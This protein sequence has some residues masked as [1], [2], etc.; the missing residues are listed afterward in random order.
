MAEAETAVIESFGGR[1]G[2]A[3]YTVL[4]EEALVGPECSLLVFTDGKSVL[5]MAPAQDH[6][7]IGEGDT[8]PNTGGMGVYSPVPFVTATEHDQMVKILERTI[9]GL[10]SQ[11]IDY[12]GVLYGGFMLTN[13]GP[14]LLEFNA[15]FGDPETQVLLPRLKSDLLEVLLKTAEGDL[16]G[17]VLEWSSDWAVSVVL[18]SAGY[19]GDYQIG[20]LISGLEKAERINGVTVDHARTALD[21]KGRLVTA[22]GRVI[23]VTGTASDFKLA[24]ELAYRGAEAIEF[25][26]KK[27]RRDIGN[28]A[29]QGRSA[30]D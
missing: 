25:E 9:A 12:R 10:T 20:K 14:K 6:K 11:G 30:W 3:G 1:F 15:R 21:D 2:P 29:L 24:R 22:G 17:M 28:R 4:I 23:N 18:A 16:S 13:D 19:P 5:P 26:G 8:G 27:Y 7:R